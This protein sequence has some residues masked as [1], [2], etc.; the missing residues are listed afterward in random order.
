[1]LN[2]I[3]ASTSLGSN[4]K[5]TEKAP[6][7]LL[8]GGLIEA[9]NF[10]KIQYQ[11]LT[12]PKN[13]KGREEQIKKNTLVKNHLELTAYNHLIYN[14][15]TTHQGSTDKLLLLG[16]DHSVGIGS[17]FATKTIEPET[18]LLYIDAHPD[19]NTPETSLSHNMH[20]MSLATVLG[21]SLHRD[22]KFPIYNYKEVIILGAKDI[23]PLEWKYIKDKKIKIYTMSDIITE[24]IGTIIKDILKFIS[25]KP[26]HVSL[27]I[28]SID[29]EY[30]PG[31]GVINKGGLSY[32][33][34]KYIAEKISTRD[35]RTIDL[36]EVNPKYDKNN[37]TVLLGIEL[38]LTL[39]GGKW[40]PYEKYIEKSKN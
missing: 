16:G 36:V 25:T 28:D 10:N 32:R 4:N 31:T 5:G 7:L 29:T 19:S 11:I 39:L 40:S 12:L 1:M 27:D 38:I 37:K 22:Y 33:E 21:D 13:N 23:D 24:G 17:M 30:A 14:L 6:E 8:K 3:K 2:I 34:I 9:L 18:V 20:G 35:I 26:L 15:A